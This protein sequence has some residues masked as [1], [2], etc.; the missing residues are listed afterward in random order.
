MY[1]KYLNKFT[2]YHTWL[3]SHHNFHTHTP[4]STLPNKTGKKD[5][6]DVNIIVLVKLDQVEKNATPPS[7]YVNSLRFRMKLTH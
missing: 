6:V 4:Y 3:Y 5:N 7:T 2:P 1:I